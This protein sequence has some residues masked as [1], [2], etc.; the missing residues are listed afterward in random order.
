MDKALALGVWRSASHAF[1]QKVRKARLQILLS[2]KSLILNHLTGN[3]LEILF[4]DLE[5]A[6]S[7]GCAPMGFVFDK[8][9]VIDQREDRNLLGGQKLNF[10]LKRDKSTSQILLVNFLIYDSDNRREALALLRLTEFQLWRIED[11]PISVVHTFQGRGVA[12]ICQI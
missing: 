4:R 1:T 10:A 7:K 8:G 12:M 3:Q 9:Q 6:K 5:Y 2:E 11:Y